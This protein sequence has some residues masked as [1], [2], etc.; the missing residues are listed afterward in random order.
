MKGVSPSFS[1]FEE[2]YSWNQ[3]PRGR[4]GITV[5]AGLDESSYSVGNLAMGADHAF[6]WI[7][8]QYGRMMYAGFGHEPAIYSRSERAN[9]AAQRDP[10]G[11][12][13]ARDDAWEAVM[14]RWRHAVMIS[15]V[16]ARGGR[17][18]E[19][20]EGRRRARDRSAGGRPHLLEGCRAN[21]SEELPGLPSSG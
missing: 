14:S 20:G 13:E 7:N 8:E 3:S 2:W 15:A 17:R 6:V 19:L 4:S 16:M 1:V 5:L 10:V 9:D 21:P 18:R 12:G 11:G